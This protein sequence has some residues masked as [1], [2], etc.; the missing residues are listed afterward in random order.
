MVLLA[1]L[2]YEIFYFDYVNE[3]DVYFVL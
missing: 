2:V 3:S 1:L